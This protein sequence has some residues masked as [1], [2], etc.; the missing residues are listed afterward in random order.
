MNRV[1]KIY[2]LTLQLDE[3]LSQEITSKNRES[4]IEQLNDGLKKRGKYM[5]QLT[6]PYTDEEKGLGS[7]LIPLNEKIEKQMQ[8]IFQGLKK[9]MKQ[10]NK[11]KKSNQSY[12]N[13]YQHVQ[14]MDG[15]FLD[16]KK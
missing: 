15:M 11:Q 8:E 6:P 3:L 5:E 10:L 2:E 1:E 13:P 16:K 9:E 7:K 12:V 14:T 4:I